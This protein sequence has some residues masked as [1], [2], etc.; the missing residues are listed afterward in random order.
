MI[1][2]V[3]SKKQTISRQEGHAYL[4]EDDWNDW[5][6]FSTLYYLQIMH[7]DTLE[8]I[9]SVKIGQRNLE[10]D[11]PNIARP[12]LPQEFTA[13]SDA[14]FSLGQD[15]YYYENIKKL[16]DDVRVVCLTALRDIAFDVK[17]YKEFKAEYIMN[18]SIMRSVS[19]RTLSNQFHRIA[20]GGARL[21][22]YNFTYRS[23]PRDE[24]IESVQL[25]FKVEPESTPATNIHVI[26]GRNGVGK[27]Y[28]ITNMIRSILKGTNVVPYVGEVIFNGIKERNQFSQVILV[29]FSAFDE[30]LVRSESKRYISIGLPK[31]SNSVTELSQDKLADSFLSSLSACEKGAKKGLLSNTLDIL[32]TDPMFVESDIANLCSTYKSSCNNNEIK[33]TFS[34]L[35]SGH[36]IILLSLIQLVENVAEQTVVFLDEP[37]G[38]LHPP[39][40]ATFVRALSDLLVKK[41]GVAII[42]T[43]SPVILQEV[44][45]SCVWKLRRT[46]AYIK[47]DRLQIESFGSDIGSLT[48]EV[49]GLEVLNSGFH[50][51]LKKLV[52]DGYNYETI[53]RKLDNQLG[54]EGRC[55]LRELIALH[56][57]QS[58]NEQDDT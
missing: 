52:N 48:N 8:D 40:L 42:A 46:G 5:W 22:A 37:E 43:H 41:N 10:V 38:H 7:N 50:G 54:S 34:R 13:L 56:K 21:T 44:P 3:I 16:G 51:L 27:T 20:L 14:F 47:A 32:K 29:S 28:L 19:S 17:I 24:S 2:H 4:T 45:K 33:K 31:N 36:K 15:D 25:Q 35:S 39:L 57:E 18:R 1:F 30:P 55:I 26:I 12:A 58:E 23:E 9:G 53:L 6:E 11:P 49:F